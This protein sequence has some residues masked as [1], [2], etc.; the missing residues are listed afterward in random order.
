MR[1]GFYERLV[2]VQDQRQGSCGLDL[3][4]KKIPWDPVVYAFPQ[5]GVLVM[6]VTRVR[7]EFLKAEQLEKNWSKLSR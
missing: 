2:F 7:H 4:C 5:V 6:E 1:M 3:W